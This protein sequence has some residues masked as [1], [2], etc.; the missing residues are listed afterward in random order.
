MSE[1]QRSI[2]L[3]ITTRGESPT[4]GRT[5]VFK[6]DNITIGTWAECDLVLAKL[7]DHQATIVLSTTGAVLRHDGREY[8]GRIEVNHLELAGDVAH[9]EVGD[10]IKMRDHSIEVVKLVTPQPRAQMLDVLKRAEA[11]KL[12]VRIDPLYV[13]GNEVN[14]WTEGVPRIKDGRVELIAE[15]GQISL[16]YSVSDEPS[17]NC[18]TITRV[19]LID[20]AP[21]NA[22]DEH[23]WHRAR[24]QADADLARFDA[25]HGTAPR[26]TEITGAA[27]LAGGRVF[28]T[29]GPARVARIAE[30]EKSVA[31][32]DAENARL[33]AA[34]SKI[35]GAL[36][37]QSDASPE[38]CVAMVE[39]L[40]D[41]IGTAN[42]TLAAWCPE[43]DPS[44][45]SLS[46]TVAMLVAD[47]LKPARR[48]ERE[49]GELR[50]GTAQLLR[51]LSDASG[52]ESPFDGNVTS[53]AIES[54][55]WAARAMVM[56]SDQLENDLAKI[57]ASLG[58]RAETMRRAEQV[59]I[60]VRLI[61]A[62]SWTDQPTT[63]EARARSSS[64]G[65]LVEFFYLL[66]RD[67]LPSGNVKGL[68]RKLAPVGD[69]VSFTSPAGEAM[70][71]E[72]VHELLTGEKP[73]REAEADM[74]TTE[75]KPEQ[76]DP[77]V[78]DWANPSIIG[79]RVVIVGGEDMG[80]HGVVE[81]ACV[82]G[83]TWVWVPVKLSGRDHYRY[84]PS[85]ELLLAPEEPSK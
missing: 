11:A 73:Q 74:V 50:T 47:V 61:R 69:T 55:L 43:V 25:K 24:R 45:S 83:D 17:V 5:V 68:L 19:E 59:E 72:C 62:A 49:L 70:A 22:H 6:Q 1:L 40:H 14:D 20:V 81:R 10:V 41:T 12:R 39:H 56:H 44:R 28:E 82:P 13:D 53:K 64:D 29:E 4:H 75:S 35:A 78:V 54:G 51:E 84:R 85:V 15:G 76:S 33:K 21:A 9:L 48:T 80:R 18:P 30:L 3:K 71:R 67:E 32:I 26:V 16:W 66:T 2:T 38:S 57:V 8:G 31:E 37:L 23:N 63:A 27:E 36:R 7:H 46:S 65:R 79:R 34:L 58:G 60:A 77:E 52:A 42:E